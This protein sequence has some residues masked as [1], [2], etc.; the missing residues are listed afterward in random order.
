MLSS[1]CGPK[2]VGCSFCHLIRPISRPFEEAF[3][4]IK[5]FLRKVRAQTVD[6]LIEAIAQ[7]LSLITPYDAIRFFTDAGFLKLD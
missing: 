6:P 3:S 1:C 4:K 2:V 7:A 5:Q